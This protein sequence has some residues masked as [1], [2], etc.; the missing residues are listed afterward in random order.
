MSRNLVIRLHADSLRWKGRL[1]VV[2]KLFIGSR[3]AYRDKLATN[4]TAPGLISRLV[5]QQLVAS[6]LDKF[7]CGK[8]G[9]R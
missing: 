2:F 4:M 3:F 9:I 8:L 1:P 6:G 5:M 7:L